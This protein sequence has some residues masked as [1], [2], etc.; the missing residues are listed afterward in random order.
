MSCTEWVQR[1]KI[2]AR[3]PQLPFFSGDYGMKIEALHK[4]IKE[5]VDVTDFNR[6]RSCT[7]RPKSK[8]KRSVGVD[9]KTARPS[10]IVFQQIHRLAW[11]G[12]HKKVRVVCIIKTD[13]SRWSYRRNR[14]WRILEW[15]VVL[16]NVKRNLPD[17]V[18]FL[19]FPSLQHWNV[20]IVAYRESFVVEQFCL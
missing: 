13:I 17:N 5:N 19:Y 9:G 7:G 2:I 10:F 3:K 18:R 16:R 14:L 20:R 8:G 1:L 4:M 6:S 15:F 12:L 11:I